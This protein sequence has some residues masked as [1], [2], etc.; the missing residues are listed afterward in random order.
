MVIQQEESQSMDL[1]FPT[2]ETVSED[3]VKSDITQTVKVP[4]Q[5]SWI[6]ASHIPHA[7]KKP[8]DEFMTYMADCQRQTNDL[9]ESSTNSSPRVS[10]IIPCC[11]ITSSAFSQS[12]SISLPPP[13]AVFFPLTPMFKDEFPKGIMQRV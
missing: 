11:S 5:R 3:E 12:L 8:V 4:S 6:L 2:S 9:D 10:R 13:G 7:S 1:P